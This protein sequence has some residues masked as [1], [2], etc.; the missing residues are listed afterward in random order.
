MSKYIPI[1]LGF[2]H[3]SKLKGFEHVKGK[4][5]AVI[6]PEFVEI[7]KFD[8]DGHH[9]FES[10]MEDGVVTDVFFRGNGYE[11]RT[12]IGGINVTGKLP[13]GGIRIRKG[14]RV[15]VLIKQLYTFDD[16]ST[17]IITN[18]ALD[19]SELYYI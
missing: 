15:K 5:N 10:V 14:E 2:E 16:T 11:V 7:H 3:Y 13:L 18:K 8:D 9:D 19:R 17:E 4:H 1:D 12:D 6:R